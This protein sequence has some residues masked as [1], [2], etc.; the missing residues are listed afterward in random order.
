VN[1]ENK[2]EEEK[3]QKSQKINVFK[4]SKEQHC[5]LS[6]KTPLLEFVCFAQSPV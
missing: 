1:N 5:Y 2:Q 3:Q 6:L 4:T